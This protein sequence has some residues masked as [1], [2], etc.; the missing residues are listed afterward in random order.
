MHEVETA[1]LLL[2]MFTEDDLDALSEIL[3][4][5]DVMEYIGKDGLPISKE[6]TSVALQ[7]II[8]HW[9]Q[10]G[11]GRWAVE[12]KAERKLI[13]YAG[14][15]SL[16][17]QAEMVYL[18]AKEYWG[19]GLA[20]EVAGACLWYGFCQKHFDSIL[21]LTRPLNVRSR[22]VMKKIGMRFE[23]YA[24]YFGIDVVQ[25]IIKIQEY[26]E[27]ASPFILREISRD[28]SDSDTQQ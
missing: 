9:Q 17:G 11:F 15:R 25:Y 24:N 20:T 1:R 28:S 14:I 13:G 6:E 16:E 26:K 21:A 10:H 5:P 3:A 23:T 19:R 12:D 27:R 22:S 18:L 7:S 8:R 2:R 4:D